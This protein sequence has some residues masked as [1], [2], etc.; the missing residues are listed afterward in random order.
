N[1]DAA[2]AITLT[3]SICPARSGDCSLS[4]SDLQNELIAQIDAGVLPQPAADST[5]NINTAYI[6]HLPPL[7]T[8]TGPDG[9]SPSFV[10]FCAYHSTATYGIDNT[11]LLYGAVMD[12]YTGACSTGCGVNATPLEN[13]TETAARELAELVTD[14][15]IGLDT[16]AVLYAFPAG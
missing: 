16:N 14:P 15:D 8:L 9:I 7:V 12:E 1:G 10:Q 4:D 2:P 5:G 13:T 3:P 11:P 6:V